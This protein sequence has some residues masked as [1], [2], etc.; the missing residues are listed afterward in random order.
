MKLK[1]KKG[2]FLPCVIHDI[3]LKGLRV[4]TKEKFPKEKF[5]NLMINISGALMLDNRFEI[6]WQKSGQEGRN[7]YGLQFVGLCDSDKERIY[8]FIYGHLSKEVVK[9]WWEGAK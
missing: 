5:I 2:A 8:S 6:C 7:V 4:S 1:N 3:T 9:K